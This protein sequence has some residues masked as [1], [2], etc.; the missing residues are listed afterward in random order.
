MGWGRKFAAMR[1]FLRGRDV[2]LGAG[3]L[4]CASVL[5]VPV[6]AVPRVA[7]AGPE[8]E[9]ASAFDPGDEFDLHLTI[10]Y[11]FTT[12]SA[13]ILREDAGAAGTDPDGLI[14]LAD[15]LVYRSARHELVPRIALG[16]FTDLELSVELPIIIR[17]TRQLDLASGVA[18]AASSTVVDGLLGESGFDSRDP[19]GPGFTNGKTLFR[20]VDRAG[21][22]QVH[23]GVTWAPMNQVRDWTKPT[24]KIGA[25]LRLAVGSAAKFNRNDPDSQKGVGRGV[26][27]IKLWT[28]LARRR[29][30]AEPFFELWWMASFVEREAGVLDAP[31]RQF[32]AA[33]SSPQQRGGSRVGVQ[34][35]FFEKK[36]AK[37]KVSL[38][39]EAN[40]T[41]HFEGRE[42]SELWEVFAYAGD[43]TAATA[44]PL[45][46][47]S[48]PTTDGV[49]AMSHPG[50][51]N[52]QN[53]LTFGTRA[54]VNAEIGPK[55][56]VGATFGLD[57]H[58]SHF[59]SF[60]DAGEDRPTC[61]G[62]VTTDCENENNDVVDPGTREVNPLHSSTIDG[63]GRRY[64]VEKSRQA[65]FMVEGR[66]LF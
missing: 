40:F 51:T 49:Q 11:R 53:Y 21:I 61:G 60:A 54:A 5:A 52:V 34:A 14:P 31:D 18:R 12:S 38:D 29:G 2:R 8:S 42:Y 15:E 32:G 44:G 7:S 20:G 17:D 62:S 39:L 65:S 30:W 3:L 45:V 36:P 4:V 35:I 56:R 10:N 6:L 37:Q 46:L 57:L 28:S 19:T 59:I 9:I 26:H 47:D 50:V 33:V 64:K 23:A 24:W 25:E 1:C 48:D 27:D 16:V 55:V 58:Q 13:N 43:S 41:A 22:D 66:F 63:V